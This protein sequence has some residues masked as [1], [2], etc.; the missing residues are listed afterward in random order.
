MTVDLNLV[1]DPSHLEALTQAALRSQLT[2]RKYLSE[3]I[4]AHAAALL[5]PSVRASGG[6]AGGAV[7]RA[8]PE[9]TDLGSGPFPWPG[10][11]YHVH[12]PRSGS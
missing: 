11:V 8:E 6:K 10:E 4:E 5:L 1:V 2:L 9:D 12:P 3:I 7:T